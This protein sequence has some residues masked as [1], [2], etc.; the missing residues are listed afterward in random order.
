VN[1]LTEAFDGSTVTLEEVRRLAIA[2]TEA[3]HAYDTHQFHLGKDS[4]DGQYRYYAE[5]ADPDMHW[6]FT[7]RLAANH[8]LRGTGR[9]EMFSEMIDLMAGRLTHAIVFECPAVFGMIEAH[10]IRDVDVLHWHGPVMW[11]DTEPVEDR[12]IG[13]VDIT[14]YPSAIEHR[15]NAETSCSYEEMKALAKAHGW[16]FYDKAQE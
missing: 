12:T 16:N 11:S 10:L 13:S 1:I 9:V 15:H 14:V 8:P 3:R 2:T 4:S 7:M 5:Y 6:E